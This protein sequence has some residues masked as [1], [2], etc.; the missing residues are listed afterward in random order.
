MQLVEEGRVDLDAGIDRHLPELAR[1]QVF[2]GLDP[3]GK[4]RLRPAKRAPTVR[5]L[6]SHTAGYGYTT[7]N[8]E[9]RRCEADAKIPCD[10]HRYEHLPLVATREHAGT[11]A[12]APRC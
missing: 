10:R 3:A 11:T 12:G 1:L 6:L 9:I 8:N 5:E 4:P 2:E 7:R